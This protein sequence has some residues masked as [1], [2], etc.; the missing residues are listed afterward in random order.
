[1]SAIE[2]RKGISSDVFTGH[3]TLREKMPWYLFGIVRNPLESFDARRYISAYYSKNW[4]SD[5]MVLDKGNYKDSFDCWQVIP[6]NAG[7]KGVWPMVAVADSSARYYEY[8]FGELKDSETVFERMV[9]W[10]KGGGRIPDSASVVVKPVYTPISLPDGTE[11]YAVYPNGIAR[12]V[13]RRCLQKVDIVEDI[14]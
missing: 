10:L 9:L 11:V 6:G 5:I 12:S 1:M 4:N 3:I 7:M 13:Q 2:N 14:E 8:K